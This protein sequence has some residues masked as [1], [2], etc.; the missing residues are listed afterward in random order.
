MRP[1]VWHTLYA[2]ILYFIIYHKI[3]PI[4][5]VIFIKKCFLKMST[6]IIFIAV[7]GYFLNNIAIHTSWLLL[8]LKAIIIGGVY[9]FT[10]FIWGLDQ[11]ER[12][13][14]VNLIKHKKTNLL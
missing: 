9:L 2:A 4:N 8:F 11:E 1:L 7:G 12:N 3:L 14:I 10:I 6:P 13:Y 5:I